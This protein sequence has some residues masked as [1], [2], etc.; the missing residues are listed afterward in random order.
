MIFTIRC[1]TDII[2]YVLKV[3][4]LIFDNI[5]TP[6]CNSSHLQSER[7]RVEGGGEFSNHSNLWNENYIAFNENLELPPS[8]NI[9]I[10]FDVFETP[11]EN[12]SIRW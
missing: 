10:I 11:K 8:S 9:N 3:I 1:I 5:S 12:T 7:V 6:T 4:E 2:L